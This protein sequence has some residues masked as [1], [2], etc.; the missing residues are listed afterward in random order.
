MTRAQRLNF[1][2]YFLYL[3]MY[4]KA[5]AV[6]SKTREQVFVLMWQRSMI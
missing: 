6:H 5:L 3:K 2:I 1:I 4:L